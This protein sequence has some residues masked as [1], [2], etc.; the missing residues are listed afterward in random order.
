MIP[1]DRAHLKEWLRDPQHV[2]PGAKMPQLPLS[3]SDI[4]ALVAYLRG[5]R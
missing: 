3:G 2:K 1:D 5:L 4:D